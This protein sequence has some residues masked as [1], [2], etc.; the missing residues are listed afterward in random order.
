NTFASITLLERHG[1]S[2]IGRIVSYIPQFTK[3]SDQSS[4]ERSI[5]Q[6][7][8]DWSERNHEG[9]DKPLAEFSLAPMIGHKK[10]HWDQVLDLCCGVGDQGHRSTGSTDPLLKLLNVQKRLWRDP[11]P[12]RHPL[13]IYSTLLSDKAIDVVSN[14]CKMTFLSA[15]D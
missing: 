11:G 8:D 10:W 4:I 5:L 1:S 3:D 12:I 15:F 7:C 9:D 2:V 6:W 13:V 14:K